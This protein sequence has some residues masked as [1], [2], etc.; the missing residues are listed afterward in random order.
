MR[1]AA[2][3]FVNLLHRRPGLETAAFIIV[4]WVGIKLAIHT[5]AHPKLAVLPHEFPESTLWKLIFWIVLIA[6][7]AGGFF[8][9]KPNKEHEETDDQTSSLNRTNA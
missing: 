5:L 6:I 7:A 2:S 4:G 9:S 1:F 8:L 3:M